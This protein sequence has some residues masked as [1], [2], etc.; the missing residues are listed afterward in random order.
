M[1]I[2]RTETPVVHTTDRVSFEMNFEL[3]VDPPSLSIPGVGTIT[4]EL[5]S[6]KVRFASNWELM[7]ANADLSEDLQKMEGRVTFRDFQL[8]DVA[9]TFLDCPFIL[10]AD[11]DE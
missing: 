11:N 4:I 10:R 9:G 2:Q 3:F 8:M 6:R 1:I 5:Q 7:E